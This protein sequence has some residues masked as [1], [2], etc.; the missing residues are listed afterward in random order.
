MLRSAPLCSANIHSCKMCLPHSSYQTYH[1]KT[2]KPVRI[3]RK[4]L[5]SQ[6]VNILKLNPTEITH[7]LFSKIFLV[8]LVAFLCN[9]HHYQ[10]VNFRHLVFSYVVLTYYSF[11]IIGRNGSPGETAKQRNDP[12]R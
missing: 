10:K 6:L 4:L 9:S 11:C 1:S 12:R 3:L 5:T 2:K 7:L 8:F